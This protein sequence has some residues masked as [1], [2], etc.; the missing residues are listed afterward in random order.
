MDLIT[1]AVKLLTALIELVA[2]IIK[3]MSAHREA[4]KKATGRKRKR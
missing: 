1:F 4:R 3:A 2:A